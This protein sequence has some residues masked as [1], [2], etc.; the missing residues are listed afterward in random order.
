M[1]RYGEYQH[2]LTASE[3]KYPA[4]FPPGIMANWYM[5]YLVFKAK[6]RH[7]VTLIACFL[8]SCPFLIVDEKKKKHKLL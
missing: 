5:K 4:L 1:S 7:I 8:C 3:N 6:K 2:G